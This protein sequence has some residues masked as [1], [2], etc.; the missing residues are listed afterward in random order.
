MIY[1]RLVQIE[2]A[3][4]VLEPSLRTEHLL[5]LLLLG[6]VE[7]VDSRVAVLRSESRYRVR[8]CEWVRVAGHGVHSGATS[9]LNT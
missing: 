7:L 8:T 2:A 9:H 4:E 6:I 1:T 5:L 3:A